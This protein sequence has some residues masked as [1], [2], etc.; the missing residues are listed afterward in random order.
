MIYE[1]RAMTILIGYCRVIFFHEAVPHFLIEHENKNTARARISFC[2]SPDPL[3][4]A[5]SNLRALARSPAPRA[6]G[7]ANDDGSAAAG[8]RLICLPIL[9]AVPLSHYVR[10]LLLFDLQAGG[11]IAMCAVFVSSFSRHLLMNDDEAAAR[12]DGWHVAD[13]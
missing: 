2:L 13:A 3:P 7:G 11:V 9:C 6:E 10:S 1:T 12:S 5:F 4:P 8:G